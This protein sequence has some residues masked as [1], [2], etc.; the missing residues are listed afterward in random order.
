VK[1]IYSVCFSINA[2]GGERLT[3]I[4]KSIEINAS[5]EK[6][7]SIT[8]FEKLPEWQPEWKRV[9]WTS[10]DK[11]KVGSTLNLVGEV[12]GF[13]SEIDLELT[14]AIENEKMAWRTIGGNMTGIG[15]ITLTP[16][17]DGTKV[18]QVIDY[19][20]PYSVLGKLIDKLRVRKAIDKSYDAAMQRLKD[21]AE[22]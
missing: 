12:A 8:Q 2:E 17:K 7:S 9:E 4:E 18:T 19:E 6:I 13:K 3:R 5:P 16:T 14:E 20:L 21:M 15:F 11:N 10:K 22:K 1:T